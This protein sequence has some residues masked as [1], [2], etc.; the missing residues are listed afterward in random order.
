MELSSAESFM[1]K[2]IF[3]QRLVSKHCFIRTNRW[4]Q[5]P[6]WGRFYSS[7]LCLFI[8][9]LF[10]LLPKAVG[11]YLCTF[12]NNAARLLG[13]M[14]VNLLNFHPYAY[15]LIY[16]C[17]HSITRGNEVPEDAANVSAGKFCAI[18]P[19]SWISVTHCLFEILDLN[20]C[21]EIRI[22][23]QGKYTQ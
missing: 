4:C 18:L 13:L 5:P 10:C 3:H 11:I 22:I 14:I 16:L 23:Q 21:S 6:P 17:Y 2:A 20:S 19:D 1:K 7:A 8:C 9:L 12:M 15:I